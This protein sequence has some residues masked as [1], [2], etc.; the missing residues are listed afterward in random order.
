MRPVRLVLPLV[1]ALALVACGDDDAGSADATT[2]TAAAPS[3]TTTVATTS[4]SSTSTTAP[5]VTSTTEDLS[6]E[7][8]GELESVLADLLIRE[9][10]L[11]DPT[12][13]DA[14]YTPPEGGG[15]CGV[16]IDSQ[17]PPASLVGAAFE[18]AENELRVLEELRAYDTV[19]DAVAAV[20][21]LRAGP[22][23]GGAADVAA[24]LDAD[25]AF[26]VETP[27]RANVVVVARVADVVAAFDVTGETDQ[28]QIAAFGIGKIS[29]FIEA[30][31]A[32]PG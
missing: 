15:P 14:G 10:E 9:G 16:D 24:E 4:S 32:P 18:S 27:E 21:S 2:T 13:L 19:D 28:R 31:A 26:L 22:A 7:G 17:L 1:A 8:I 29:A 5:A 12:L 30:G 25:E 6:G 20:S 11:G 3:T 23:C